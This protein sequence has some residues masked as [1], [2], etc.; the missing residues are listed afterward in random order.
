[1][2]HTARAERQIQRFPSLIARSPSGV[3]FNGQVILRRLIGLAFEANIQGELASEVAKARPPQA[4]ERLPQPLALPKRQPESGT[5]R[6][7]PT[8][9]DHPPRPALFGIRGKIF[10][11]RDFFFP[12]RSDFGKIAGAMNDFITNIV[13]SYRAR[14]G[15]LNESLH[16]AIWLNQPPL[17]FT[18]PIWSTN[19]KRWPAARKA[20]KLAEG[21]R[22]SIR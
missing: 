6:T 18:R 21:A 8:A 20:R 15:C 5:A 7:A 1:V 4:P 13:I 3:H 22:D 9:F 17:I 2:G 16:G 19:W 11:S 10:V 12:T 14:P